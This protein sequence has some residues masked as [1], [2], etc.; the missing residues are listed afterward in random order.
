[1][2][3]FPCNK[4][5]QFCVMKSPGPFLP[6]C[7]GAGSATRHSSIQYSLIHALPHRHPDI[8]APERQAPTPCM[9]SQ[10]ASH[11]HQIL[12]NRL[13][14]TALN[15]VFDRCTSV[16]GQQPVLHKAALS[17]DP[18]QIIGK[19]AQLQ[20]K[21]IGG[22]LSAW[23]TLKIHIG[24]YLRMKLLAGAMLVIQLYDLFCRKFQARPVGGDFQFRNQ[25]QLPI[26]GTGSFGHLKHN[27]I[28]V[29]VPFPVGITGIHLFA[30]AGECPFA[31]ALCIQKPFIH[32][33]FANVSFNFKVDNPK[34]NPEAAKLLDFRK[35]LLSTLFFI[36]IRFFTFKSILF[37]QYSKWTNT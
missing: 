26:S 2:S 1:M 22:K 32:R 21:G 6:A 20:H 35:A 37:K 31:E 7:C 8:A 25:Q 14:S 17:Y 11:I 16:R 29:A 28:Q 13:Q 24:L 3:Q 33:L 10:P 27:P 23:K 5:H 4:A 34:V 30:F 9:M 36:I 19:H 18:E 15:P 12:D